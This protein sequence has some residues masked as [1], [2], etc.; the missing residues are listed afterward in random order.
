MAT[1]TW[2]DNKAFKESAQ[3]YASKSTKT[4]T[5]AAWFILIHKDV[6]VYRNIFNTAN[7]SVAIMQGYLLRGILE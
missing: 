3:Y 5:S 2:P 7:K 6:T 4:Q 1:T